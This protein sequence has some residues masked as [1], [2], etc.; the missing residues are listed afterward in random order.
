M[1]R[2]RTR[3]LPLREVSPWCPPMFALLAAQIEAV[4]RV[5]AASERGRPGTWRVV[6]DDACA[7]RCGRA[8]AGVRRTRAAE[9]R[10][11]LAVLR[12]LVAGDV[13][14]LLVRRCAGIDEAARAPRG[15][16]GGVGRAVVL[17]AVDR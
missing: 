1:R 11:Q 2:A 8:R 6:L 7:G 14:A 15:V 16:D 5:A 13:V 9:A 10:R 12:L 3:S 17:T 4:G